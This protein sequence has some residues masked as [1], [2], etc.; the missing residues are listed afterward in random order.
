MRGSAAG[1][2]LERA[3]CQTEVDGDAVDAEDLGDAL[4]GGLERVRDRELGGRLDDD[5]EQRARA[6]ELERELP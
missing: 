4:D 6:R 1:R 3:V 2:L 5:L